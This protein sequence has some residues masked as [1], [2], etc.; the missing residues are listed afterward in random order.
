MYMYVYIRIYIY[1]YNINCISDRFI[2]FLW[3]TKYIF[4]SVVFTADTIKR[5]QTL[6]S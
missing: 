2:G 3:I 4:Y 5:Y 6:K 1:T